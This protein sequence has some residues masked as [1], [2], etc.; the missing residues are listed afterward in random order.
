MHVQG[1]LTGELVEVAR[2]GC[3]VIFQTQHN[4]CSVA[5]KTIQITMQSN[6]A[7]CLSVSVSISMCFKSFLIMGFLGIL[8]RGCGMETSSTPKH[9]TITWYR[10]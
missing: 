5:I 3:A 1:H 8:P 10:Y 2:G 9:S 6:F 7:R 4:N